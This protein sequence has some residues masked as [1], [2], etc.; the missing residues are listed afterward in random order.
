[1]SL[2]DLQTIAVGTLSGLLASTGFLLAMFIGFLVIAGFTKFRGRGRKSMIV[3]DLSERMGS[4]SR[5]LSPTAPRGP[6]D[7]LQTPEL[8]E[9][10]SRQQ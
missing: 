3:R 8:L 7:Q 10:S 9:Q 2:S 4:K 5:Y 6:S 1:M